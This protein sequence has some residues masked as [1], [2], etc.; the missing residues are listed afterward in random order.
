VTKS[1]PTSDPEKQ[2]STS[3]LNSDDRKHRTATETMANPLFHLRGILLLAPWVVWLAVVDI[4]VSLLLPLRLIFPN[5]SYDLSSL[6]A[7]SVWRWIQ[8]IFTHANGARITISGDELPRGESAVVV[9]NHVGWS[10]FYMIQAM[11]MQAG[12]LGRCRYFAKI[13]L[14]WVPFLGWGLWGLGMPMVSRKWDRDRRELDR[15]F[16]GIVNRGWPACK[17][18]CQHHIMSRPL[19]A[20]QGLSPFPR[21]RV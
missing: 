20:Y 9:A 8:F 21:Q 2:R 1:T 13:Q 4:G 16:G 10:D 19:T 11:A 7:S 14:R 5:G 18:P 12:M 17:R 3:K 6:L 15:V